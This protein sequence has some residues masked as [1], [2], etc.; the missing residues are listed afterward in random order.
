MY[1]V[2]KLSISNSFDVD[3]NVFGGLLGDL[4]G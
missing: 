1:G 2:L 3:M 4:K